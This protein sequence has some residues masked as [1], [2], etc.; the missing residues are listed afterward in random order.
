MLNKYL[1]ALFIGSVFTVSCQNKQEK[2]IEQLVDN[3]SDSIQ[4]SEEPEEEITSIDLT[5]IEHPKSGENAS[6]FNP[7]PT[8]LEIQYEAQGDLNGDGLYDL[9][10]V[11]KKMNSYDDIRPTLVL[12]QNNDKTF[13]L[14]K[15]SISAMPEEFTSDKYKNYDTE[16]V[17]IIDGS[18]NFQLY[19]LGP[20]GNLFS[21]YQYRENEFILV[22]IETYNMGAGSHMSLN[23]DVENGHIIQ[24]IMNTMLEEMPTTSKTFNV[25]KQKILFENAQTD[26]IMREAFKQIDSDW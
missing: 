22:S 5:N 10:I 3:T 1:I 25:T 17:S 4:I 6:D 18:L 12:L 19:A 2:E 24:V 14:D 8:L 11:L 9:V 23:Y 13:R 7:Y 26:S 21:T 15:V 16:D 20:N